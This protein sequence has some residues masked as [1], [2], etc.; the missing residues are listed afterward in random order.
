MPADAANAKRD[1]DGG[2]GFL[3]KLFNESVGARLQPTAA[4]EEDYSEMASAGHSS[5]H[6][7]HSVHSEAL[8][9][10]TL[11]FMVIASAGHASTHSSQPVHSSALILGTAILIPPNRG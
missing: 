7:P 9:T 10:A 6:A 2:N 11:L 3:T 4:V 8:I 1:V 5:T